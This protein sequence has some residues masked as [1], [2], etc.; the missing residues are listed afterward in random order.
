MT[1]PFLLLTDDCA[2]K[3]QC[4]NGRCVSEFDICDG[5]DQC[6]D[7]SD[8]TDCGETNPTHL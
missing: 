6:G 4:S 3:F 7:F 2:G 1:K 8:E 5:T